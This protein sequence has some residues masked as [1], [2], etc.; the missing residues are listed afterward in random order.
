MCELLNED[1]YYT[2]FQF[3]SKKDGC[4]L[5]MSNKIIRFNGIIAFYK[6]YKFRTKEVNKGY[7]TIVKKLCDVIDLKPLKKF[8]NITRLELSNNFNKVIISKYLPLSISI[9]YIGKYFKKKIVVPKSIKH[10][11]LN[12]DNCHLDVSNFPTNLKIISLPAKS[13]ITI[14]PCMD[15]EIAIEIGYFDKFTKGL[16]SA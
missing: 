13:A 4:R 8:P 6:S 15:K 9:M 2:L 12:I 1:V 11:Y 5:M 7:E 3:I 14:K 10:L 16:F